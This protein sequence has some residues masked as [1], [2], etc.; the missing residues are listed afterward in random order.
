MLLDPILLSIITGA[1]SAGGAYAAVR[2]E[3]RFLWRDLERVSAELSRAHRRLDAL[4]RG[5]E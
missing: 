4:A 2:L 1:A 5:R 3:L